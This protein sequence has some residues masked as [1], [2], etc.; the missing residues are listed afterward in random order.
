MHGKSTHGSQTQHSSDKTPHFTGCPGTT[1]TCHMRDGC[2]SAIWGTQIS[3]F[4]MVS[5]PLDAPQIP[6]TYMFMWGPLTWECIPHVHFP[7][8]VLHESPPILISH[9]ITLKTS[10]HMSHILNIWS[11]TAFSCKIAV[12]KGVLL[13]KNVIKVM[14][15]QRVVDTRISLMID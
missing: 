3:N 4:S 10:W 12:E 14:A 6:I 9:T 5:M 2:I 13:G 11:M 1:A 15:A 8:S 7:W